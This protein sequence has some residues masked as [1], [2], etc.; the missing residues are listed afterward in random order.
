[1]KKDKKGK[2]FTLI[3]LLVVIAIIAI[4]ASMLLPALN[5]ARDKG[6]MSQCSG[7]LRQ[8]TAAQA[9]YTDDNNG[10]TSKGEHVPNH[11]LSSK[12]KGGIGHYIGSTLL[13][14][15]SGGILVLI[16]VSEVLTEDI[17]RHL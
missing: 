10:W 9:A 5:K 11:W 2:K 15:A 6:H 12:E 7:N 13:E 16:N 17:M 4:L 14:I 8:I 1:M 3:E